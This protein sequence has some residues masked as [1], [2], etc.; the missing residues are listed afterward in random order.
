MWCFVDMSA[1]SLSGLNV[2][3]SSEDATD[4]AGELCE[5]GRRLAANVWSA[6]ALVVLSESDIVALSY[7]FAYNVLA[8]N[9]VL[10]E[11]KE[12]SSARLE[13]TRESEARLVFTFCYGAWPKLHGAR[14][15]P[16]T[17]Q[18]VTALSQL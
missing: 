10:W 15:S 9:D 1:S 6:R 17:R 11:R 18:H 2:D 8:G 13:E 16:R 14:L 3:A 12:E 5:R 4:G 7:A